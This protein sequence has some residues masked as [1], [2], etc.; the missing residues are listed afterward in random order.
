MSFILL[1]TRQE[2]LFLQQDS[3][4]NVAIFPIPLVVLRL[5]MIQLKKLIDACKTEIGIY[6]R[7]L[8][9]KEEREKITNK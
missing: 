4:L 5:F 6:T 8:I 2:L 1:L 3:I 9:S 7:L